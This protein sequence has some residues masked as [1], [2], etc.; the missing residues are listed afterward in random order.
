MALHDR[1]L[2]PA[3]DAPVLT[4]TPLGSVDDDPPPVRELLARM[5]GSRGFPALSAAVLRI[6]HL[7][8][9]ESENL[10]TL[11]AEILKD[12][13]LTQK[14]LRLVNTAHF[15]HAGAGGIGTVSRAV[16]LI[17]FRGVRDLALSLVLLEHLPDKAQARLREE[18]LRVLLAAAL[19][20]ELAGAT[21]AGE[22]A[23]VGTLFQGLG[24]LL[25]EYY[26][27]IE[28]E[29]V[30][31][32]VASARGTSSVLQRDAA[33]WQ[34]LGATL[35]QIGR[36]VARVWG[37]PD[38][39]LRCMSV[40]EPEQPPRRA[41]APGEE[42]QR[43]LGRASQELA[44]LMLA[45]PV[46][47]LPAVVLP[48]AQRY[49]PVLDIGARDL[50]AAA[51]RMR[52]ALPQ[53]ARALG[54]ESA[55][56]SEPAGAPLSPRRGAA[57]IAAQPVEPT[58][59]AILTD[60]VQDLTEMLLAEPP[61]LD[62]VLR[63]WIEVVWRG[64]RARHVVL[65]LRDDSRHELV[66][67]HALGLESPAA[68]S[69]FRVPLSDPALDPFAWL[70]LQGA[71]TLIADARGGE[72]AARLPRWYREH[73]DAGTL[74]LMPLLHKGRPLGL[75][76]A[77]RAAPTSFEVGEKEWPLLR[78]LRNQVLLALRQR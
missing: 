55:L 44:E 36:A 71:D 30:R 63:L 61:E 56:R 68:L 47:R 5:Q 66:A 49:A 15:S 26:C 37:L 65:C 16:A 75:L 27:P 4:V 69:A 18:Y 76:Y 64:L 74:L 1:E 72:F 50:V 9:S 58:A 24:R 35:S 8:S 10:H 23:F 29:R 54:L 21:Q 73:I 38:E 43:W 14:L 17:G 22:A 46:E 70:C 67:R 34:V 77:D 51:E 7:T 39:L 59:Q 3:G 41:A 31:A 6:Q 19:A 57:P 20:G 2:Q 53:W 28:A 48:F 32:L 25:V 52:V 42:R 13:A 11:S 40:P 33:A 60:G 78:T 45:T 12:V 62:A